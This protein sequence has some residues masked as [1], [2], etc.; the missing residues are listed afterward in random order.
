MK[1]YVQVRMECEAAIIESGLNATILRP[2]YILG[3]GHRWPIILIPFYWL[4]ERFERTR[5]GAQRL[6][7]V[8]REEMLAALLRA[9]ETP[10]P[11]VRIEDVLS[12][13]RAIP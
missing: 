12:I 1:A 5:A 9:V 10:G 11:G 8:T 7:L 13:R 6:G 4:M 2:W 3:P